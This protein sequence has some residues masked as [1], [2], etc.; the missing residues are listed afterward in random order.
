MNDLTQAAG[1]GVALACGVLIGLE[2]ERVGDEGDF[3]GVRTF[4]LI[5]LIGAL[6]WTLS[7]HLGPWIV[8][9]AFIGLVIWLAI[10]Y[11]QRSSKGDLGLTGES[12]ALVTFLLGVLAATGHLG[13]SFALAIAVTVI[14]ALKNALHKAIR[15]INPEDVAATLKFLLIAFVVLPLLP[16]TTWTISIPPDLIP[17]WTNLDQ[18]NIALINPSRVGWMVVLIAGISFT[19]YL[20]SK[21]LSARKGLGLTAF[22]GGLASSTAV[23]LSFAGR[24]RETPALVDTC[25]IAILV[26]STTMFFRVII[27]VATV[28]PAL[29]TAVAAPIG[30]MGIC[31]LLICGLL[32]WSQRRRDA[33]HTDQEVKLSNPFELSQAFKFGALFALVQLIAHLAQTL[34]GD[35]GLYLSGLLT[36][37]TDVDAITLSVAQLSRSE[38]DPL[39]P[40][41]AVITITIA[42]IANTVS[43]GL[44]ALSLGGR[45]LGVRVLGSVGVIALV[46]AGVAAWTL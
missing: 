10:Y 42:S 21:L 25:T 43:K 23:T 39:D 31:G 16:T 24:A 2:R 46:G 5:A 41:T 38:I 32:A 18:W 28:A 6:S 9:F 8:G 1:F 13:L 35:R 15:N 4:P 29:L 17:R 19:G 11:F 26:A 37:L 34:F 30:A 20:A 36:G 27:E 7:P 12:A 40:R 33:S 45:A 14:L 3:G 22:L 44:L